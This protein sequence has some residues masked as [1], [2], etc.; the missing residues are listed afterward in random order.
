MLA[1]PE[2]SISDNAIEA[3]VKLVMADLCYG[4]IQDLG[5]HIHGTREM[6]KL[7]GGLDT[8]GT[9]TALSRMVLA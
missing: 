6:V 9:N 7:R 5:V 8:L 3:V 2:A 4:E 1:I